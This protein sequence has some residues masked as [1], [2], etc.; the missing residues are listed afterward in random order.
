MAE[1]PPQAR[2][3]RD[4]HTAYDND[5]WLS[6][7]LVIVQQRIREA[8]GRSAPGPIRVISACAGEGRDLLGVLADHPRAD[9]VR[10]RLVE[11]D[12]VLAQTARRDA[13]SGIDVLCA[14]A[15]PTRCYEGF[16]PAD[17]VLVCGLF[18]NI[19]DDDIAN[20][21]RLVPS[22]CAPDATVIWTR[23]RGAPDL[24]GTVRSWFEQTGFEE[25]SF[26][27]VEG[28]VAVGAH[29]LTAS[30]APYD[31]DQRLFTTFRI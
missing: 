17:L 1:I 19:S 22:L 20:T 5:T 10:G 2:Y 31:P 29:R 11:L 26:D 3:W 25:V 14:D 7:R 8:I 16:V 6:K 30:P 13:P 28:V 18:G 24:T 9:D 15:A 21:I 4:W 27:D 23:H 12:P